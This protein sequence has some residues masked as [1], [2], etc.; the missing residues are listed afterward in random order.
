M[1]SIAQA[2]L[3][4]LAEKLLSSLVEADARVGPLL[5]LG[6]DVQHLLHLAHECCQG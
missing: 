1:L 2:V 6:I 4:L 5:G 3:A